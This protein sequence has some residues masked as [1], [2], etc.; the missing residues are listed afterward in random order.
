MLQKL[1]KKLLYRYEKKIIKV[2][3]MKKT[4]FEFKLTSHTKNETQLQK[5]VYHLRVIINNFYNS[6]NN[7]IIIMKQKY[8][9]I[10]ISNSLITLNYMK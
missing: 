10:M 2:T 1:S 5:E 3:K 6:F 7:F 8:Q 4:K 9:G